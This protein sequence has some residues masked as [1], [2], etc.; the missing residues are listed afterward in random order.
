MFGI[1]S[2]NEANAAS[3]SKSEANFT[4]AIE[5]TQLILNTVTKSMDSKIDD[6]TKTI[7][8]KI[9][10]L[11]SRLDKGEGHSK[12][13]SDVWGWVLGAIGIMLSLG[14]LIVLMLRIGAHAG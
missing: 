4:K 10:D 13:G 5:Q 6:M 8:S 11:K 1:P 14:T 3:F 9:N 7:D 2:Q 12:G